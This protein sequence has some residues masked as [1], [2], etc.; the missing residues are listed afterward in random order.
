MF[1]FVK[2][3]STPIL[4]KKFSETDII[5]MV[6]FLID[7]IFVIFGGVFFN[8]QSIFLSLIT[9]LSFAPTC[10]F[11]CTRQTSK[12]NKKKLARFFYFTFHYIYAV[13]SL[14]NSNF[15]DFV[16][17]IYPI[18]LEIKDTKYTSRSASYLDLHLK[19]DNERELR[20]KF[21]DKWDDFNFQI[22]N[23]PFIWSNIPAA[24]AYGEYLSF[25]FDISKLV[26]HIRIPLIESS[27]NK[28]DTEV[29]IC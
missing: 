22:V 23:F 2:K 14:N 12:K 21:H 7:N 10:S 27:A 28:E 16:D 13:L 5:K 17:C 25:L 8:R 19:I 9:A 3:K 15:D 4:P 11:I 20:T 1:Y 26:V 18:K 29:P 24:P 6:E